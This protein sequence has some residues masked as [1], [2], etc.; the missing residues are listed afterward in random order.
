[1]S[2]LQDTQNTAAPGVIPPPV[3]AIK[4]RRRNW[5]ESAT[6]FQ[7]LLICVIGCAIAFAFQLHRVRVTYFE[8]E[9]LPADNDAFYHARRILDT[10]ADPQ[11]FY[12]FDPRIHAPDGT[13]LPWPW[14]FDYLAAGAVRLAVESGL[15]ADSHTAL[16]YLPAFAVILSIILVTVIAWQLRLGPIAMAMLIAAVAMSP[17]TQAIHGL[18]SVDHHFG[19]Y[20][21]V[22]GFLAAGLSWLNEP[23]SLPR[24][25]AAGVVLGFA[26]AIH[27]LLFVLQVPLLLAICVNWIRCLPLDRNAAGAFASALAAGTVL[28]V[29]PSLPLHLG[30]SEHYYLDWFHVYV[31]S[32][33]ILAIGLIAKL[34]WSSQAL[35][36]LVL[37][38]LVLL[39]PIWPQ[40]QHAAGFLSDESYVLHDIAEARSVWRIASENSA[41]V[42]RLYSAL[43]IFAPLLILGYLLVGK[44]TRSPALLL[45]CIYSAITLPML[46]AQFRFHYYGSI[47]LILLPILT[48]DWFWKR[49]RSGAGAI[50]AAVVATGLFCVLFAPA[51]LTAIES[52]RT[53]GRDPYFIL[54]RLAMPALAKA[55]DEDPGTVLAKSNDGNAILYYTDCSVISN[56]FLIAPDDI[57]A[58]YLTAEL[59][60][61]TPTEVQDSAPQIKYIL[62]R[63]RGA[64]AIRA[65]GSGYMIVDR[66]DAEVVSDPL[67]DALLWSDADDVP[68]GFELV[69]EIPIPA[70]DYPYA[71]IWKVNGR[72]R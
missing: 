16:A 7:A 26:P 28:A 60:N 50:S 72:E 2:A 47:A 59:F 69:A 20:L 65:D 44:R 63:A 46:L 19:E 31:A 45:L 3:V 68:T 53:P 11:A 13:L 35:A 21:F 27:T 70:H 9:I 49:S 67:T 22:L 36:T 33:T 54:T 52:E 43:I 5:T 15:A 1:M 62:V 41:R 71:R 32:C 30:H 18:G 37:L 40:L 17:L 25:A 34:H 66:E 57:R 42:I 24:A 48:L 23:R 8:G 10:A 58:F 38:G 4:T 61:K 55:C 12:Q 56:N 64:I 29:I 39:L 51:V 14:G 6:A